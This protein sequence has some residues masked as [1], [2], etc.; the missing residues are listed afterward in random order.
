MVSNQDDYE[1]DI[2]DDVYIQ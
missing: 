2:R 1:D